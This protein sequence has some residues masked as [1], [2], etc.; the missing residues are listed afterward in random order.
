MITDWNKL[1]AK[2]VPIWIIGLMSSIPQRQYYSFGKLSSYLREHALAFNISENEYNDVL[3]TDAP[4]LITPFLLELLN[5]SS[6]TNLV[7]VL[8]LLRT[9]ASYIREP[10][11]GQ[12]QR[13]RAIQISR[14]IE[15]KYELYVSL[16]NH[17][18][19]EVRIELILLLCSISNKQKESATLLL[20]YLKTGDVSEDREVLTI[21]DCIFTLTQNTELDSNLL[22]SELIVILEQSINHDKTSDSVLTR[23]VCFL[24]VLQG[25]KVSTKIINHLIDKLKNAQAGKNSEILSYGHLWINGLLNLGIEKATQILLDVFKH[26]NDTYTLFYVSAI[27]LRIQFGSQDPYLLYVHI[28][29]TDN[30]YQIINVTFE[31]EFKTKSTWQCYEFS[32]SQKELLVQLSQKSMLWNYQSNLFD[33][34]NLPS[35]RFKLIKLLNE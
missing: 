5:Y 17:N 9:V 26:Q 12:L 29:D 4:I 32:T 22:K 6:Q 1:N 28:M 19:F 34:F 31:P 20:H 24:L 16:L 18:D 33:S 14:I 30:N 10:K 2:K 13:A 15:E 23:A 21:F 25:S 27:L 35:D 11:L 7:Y 3:E 8:R